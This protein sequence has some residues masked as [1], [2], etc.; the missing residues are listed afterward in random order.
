MKSNVLE[1]KHRDADEVKIFDLSGD[2]TLFADDAVNLHI[3]PIINDGAIKLILNFTD[4]GYINSSGIAIIIGLVTLLSNKGG[5]FRSFGLSPHFQKVF[6]MVGL[7][8]YMDL[9][10]NEEE[11]LNSFNS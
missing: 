9:Y 3:K 6:T 4:T 11:A 1:I 7:T 8:Q 2:F 5:R 10:E